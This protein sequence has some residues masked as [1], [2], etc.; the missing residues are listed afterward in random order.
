[1]NLQHNSAA[2]ELRLVG[3]VF[4]RCTNLAVKAALLER[5]VNVRPLASYRLVRVQAKKQQVAGA[6]PNPP[7]PPKK[8]V[9]TS[10]S[11][12]TWLVL[13]EKKKE[14]GETLFQTL[15]RKAPLL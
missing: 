7:C 2:P 3:A 4:L 8:G 5:D 9:V 10:V 6:V 15:L 13:R 1:M 14:E 11:A 12:E